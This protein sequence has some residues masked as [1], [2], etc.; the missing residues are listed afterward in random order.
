MESWTDSQKSFSSYNLKMYYLRQLWSTYIGIILGVLIRSTK[1]WFQIYIHM[2]IYIFIMSLKLFK[3]QKWIGTKV[4]DRSYL[5]RPKQFLFVFLLL[6]KSLFQYKYYKCETFYVLN[7]TYFLSP[8]IF[9][10]FP[11]CL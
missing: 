10:N 8:T 2:Y 1:T 5:A 9:E 3:M 7:I 4:C 6:L 11:I